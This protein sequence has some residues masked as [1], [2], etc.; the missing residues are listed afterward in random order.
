[1][2]GCLY[3]LSVL[4]AVVVMCPFAGAQTP[5]KITA[6]TLS[7]EGNTVTA[8][9]NV[10]IRRGDLVIKSDSAT[11]NRATGFLKAEG[12]VTISEPPALLYCRR[13]IYRTREGKAIL[14][15][16]KG[17]IS[18]NEHIEA[19]T[20]QRLSE[21][22]WIAYDGTYT[23]CGGACPDWSL[24]A[25]HFRILLGEGF[26]GKWVFF[27]VK[28]VPTVFSPY[29]S[30][31]MV[32]DR[33]TGF[34]L[35]KLAY[36]SGEGFVYSQPLFIA[37][38]RSADITTTYERRGSAGSGKRA[39]LRYVLSKHSAGTA[40]YYRIDTKDR[41]DWKFTFSHRHQPSQ[42]LYGSASAEL[43]SSRRFYKK[44][45]FEVEETTQ[46]Y[47]KSK[48]SASKLWNS[49]IVSVSGVYLN[50]LEG[51]SSGIYQKTP[52][53]NLYVMSNPVGKLPLRMFLDSD[54]TYFYREAGNSGYRVNIKPGVRHTFYSGSVKN[55]ATFSYLLSGYKN[56]SGRSIAMF[57]NVLSST[58]YTAFSHLS[59]SL[60]P[61]LKLKVVEDENQEGN[62]RYEPSDRLSKEGKLSPS[63]TA[64]IY[65]KGRRF[66]RLFLEGNYDLRDSQNRWG[67]WKASAELA[68]FTAF[69][70]RET[71]YYLP[72]SGSFGAV[73][74]RAR[75]RLE[76]ASLW[77]NYYRETTAED[78]TYLRWGTSV[79]LNSFVTFSFSD[80]YDL[81]L[82]EDRERSY[83]LLVNRHC[84]SGSLTYRWI[85]NFDSTI[86]YQ[87]LLQVNLLRLGGYS[88]TFYKRASQ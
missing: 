63:L 22:E 18:E 81:K 3:L 73:N 71:L 82:S 62:P 7:R 58:G 50:Y 55:T 54:F 56:G 15:G 23:P 8:E 11:Y 49:A 88:Y 21:K 48:V 74:T 61:E 38:G 76:G 16:V 67:L 4:F 83:H 66:G 44:G 69:D 29:L 85:K 25:R 17:R 6:D 27:K 2:K 32:K 60:N 79:P 24:K 51:S 9:G 47:T 30:G 59:L 43:V 87:I 64:Y 52:S 39:E 78:I 86:D 41:Q 5:V 80:R 28:E 19:Q 65:K 42:E 26:K 13:L 37:L 77:L 75:L 36:A 20:L 84:W 1:M 46:V 33:T 72:D 12:N 70:V 53:V 14:E 34:L 10:V 57:E 40:G 31:P 68:P 35:P 45:E